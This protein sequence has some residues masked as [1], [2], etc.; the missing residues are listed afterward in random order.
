MEKSTFP[1]LVS[2]Q[3]TDL[4]GGI[5]LYGNNILCSCTVL[6]DLNDSFFF[7]IRGKLT[8]YAAD[9]VYYLNGVPNDT[10][11]ASWMTEAMGTYRGPLPIFPVEAVVLVTE[12]SISILDQTDLLN[13]WM[14]FARDTANTYSTGFGI[15]DVA[16]TA[17]VVRYEQGVITVTMIPT[18]G[19]IFA[20]PAFL[21]IDFTKDTAYVDLY[22]S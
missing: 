9:G 11:M 1:P 12:E 10:N 20:S 22:S 14:V 18:N 19:S 5:Q 6:N 2:D 3:S 4:I 21:H 7:P 15:S 17:T 16:F 13:M 8:G